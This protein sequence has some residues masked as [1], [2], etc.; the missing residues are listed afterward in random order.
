MRQEAS[1]TVRN[2]VGLWLEAKRTTVRESTWSDYAE[3]ANRWII[4]RLG[5]TPVIELRPEH[6]LQMYRALEARGLSSRTRCY[7]HQ[8][9]RQSL[10][11]AVGLR[12]IRYNPARQIRAPSYQRKWPARLSPA[13]IWR[14]L[15]TARKEE[16]GALWLVLAATGMRPCEAVGLRWDDLALDGSRLRIEGTL[17][18]LP[19][20]TWRRLPLPAGQVREIVVSEAVLLALRDHQSGQERLRIRAPS[21]WKENGFIFTDATGQPLQWARVSGKQFRQLLRR[22]GL[23]AVPAFSLRHSYIEALLLRG[24]SPLAISRQTGYSSLARMLSSHKLPP[25]P[26]GQAHQWN[27]EDLYQGAADGSPRRR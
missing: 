19:D 4:P 25:G 22:A 24:E 13:E 17:R 27:L 11:H 6:L 5:R 9:L 1:L 10:D 15:E 21:E 2:C 14:F 16:L 7:I 20:G 12:L 26:D 18:F 3:K 8:V 23:P